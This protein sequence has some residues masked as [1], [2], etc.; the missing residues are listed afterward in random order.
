LYFRV[1][2]PNEV[3]VLGPHSGMFIPTLKE[4]GSEEQIQKWVPQAEKH[5]IM[6]TYIQTELGHGM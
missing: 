5:Q 3:S 2:F 6:G 4:Q 1:A